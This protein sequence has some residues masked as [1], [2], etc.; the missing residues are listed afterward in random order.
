MNR[1]DKRLV[2]GCIKQKPRAQKEF[3]DRFASKMLAV[4]YR[5]ARDM[6]EAEDMLQEAFIKVFKRLKSYQFQGSLEGW[7]RRIVVNTSIDYLRKHKYKMKETHI[8]G[9]PAEELSTELINTLDL[10]YL[11]Q[12]IQELPVGYR[13]VF[14]MYAIEG[15]SH[16]EIGEKLK[17]SASTSRSQY[18][19]AR[20]I[21]VNRIQSESMR[22]SYQYNAI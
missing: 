2:E 17:I 16:A 20:K 10:E 21:L 3:Y 18:A 1:N 4:C 22:E 15:Y 13:L 8:D 19:R 7:V 14:N 9:S 12:L 5:Y 11:Y 6:A